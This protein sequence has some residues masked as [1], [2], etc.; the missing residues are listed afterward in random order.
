MKLVIFW[1]DNILPHKEVLKIVAFPGKSS[2]DRDCGMEEAD[3]PLTGAEPSKEHQLHLMPDL[4]AEKP[5]FP[6]LF[7]TELLMLQKRT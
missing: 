4:S 6:A 3:S 2:Y 7:S 1:E 5:D